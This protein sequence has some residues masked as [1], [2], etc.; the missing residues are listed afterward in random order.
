[1]TY[2]TMQISPLTQSLIDATRTHNSQFVTTTLTSLSKTDL[3]I[4]AGELWNSGIADNE[5][6]DV[7]NLM[8][9]ALGF[10]NVE[11]GDKTDTAF[12]KG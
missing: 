2:S 7:L 12:E 4:V 6:A 3:N 8:P 10:K 1:M 11:A 9:A 5:R